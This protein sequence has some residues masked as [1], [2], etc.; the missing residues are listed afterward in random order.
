K[1][2]IRLTTARWTPRRSSRDPIERRLD[3][4]LEFVEER[5]AALPFGVFANE[6]QEERRGVHRAVVRRMWDFAQSGHFAH[7]DFMQNLPRLL[8]APF[9]DQ[10]SLKIGE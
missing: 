1:S 4:S 2:H 10:L 3:V 6:D 9:V 5:E 8:F 7:A